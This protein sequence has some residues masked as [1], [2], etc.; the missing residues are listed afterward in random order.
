MF[1]TESPGVPSNTRALESQPPVH[2]RPRERHWYHARAA[3]R[4]E[5]MRQHVEQF[6]IVLSNSEVSAPNNSTTLMLLVLVHEVPPADAVLRGQV[7]GSDGPSRSV[8]VKLR[9]FAAALERL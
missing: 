3:D 4:T 6:R 9:G 5:S 2:P 8:R 7:V 1:Y